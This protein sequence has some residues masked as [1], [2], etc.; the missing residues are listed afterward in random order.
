MIRLL[1]GIGVT[2]LI[3]CTPAQAQ[4]AEAVLKRAE[5][6]N[7]FMMLLEHEDTAIRLAAMEQGLQSEDKLIRSR[8]LEAGL[9]SSDQELQTMA[10][11]AHMSYDPLVVVDLPDGVELS[12]SAKE[13]AEKLL[14]TTFDRTDKKWNPKN[15]KMRVDTFKDNSMDAQCQVGGG[16]LQCSG[17]WGGTSVE[18][19]LQPTEGDV[20]TGDLN[21]LPV[22]YKYK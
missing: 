2:F 18:L 4:D 3:L 9:R 6:L 11:I 17:Y 22:I 7:K 10:M 16:L 14:P 19:K 21:G 8:S 5:K 12:G 20:F 13:M 1:M 15:F